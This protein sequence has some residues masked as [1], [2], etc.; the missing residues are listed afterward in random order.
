MISPVLHSG[1]GNQLFQ[2]AAAFAYAKQLN[3]PL[4]IN[5]ALFVKSSH[6][7][8]DYRTNVFSKIVAKYQI[9]DQ[10]EQVYINARDDASYSDILNTIKSNKGLNSIIDGY[11]QWE[12]IFRGYRN[13]I[14]SQF[15]ISAPAPAALPAGLD[16]GFFLHFRRGDY[17]GSAFWRDLTGYYL[18]VIPLV[19]ELCEGRKGKPLPKFF[20]IS[21]DIEYC[22]TSIPY[23]S[24]LDVEFI[25]SADYSEIETMW[26]M[27]KCQLG[28][29]A[30]NSTFSW[31]GLY[32]NYERPLLCIP[33]CFDESK[34]GFP[35]VTIVRC[36]AS[37][38]ASA[39]AP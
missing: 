13:E 17:V 3:T 29:A 34:Y 22:K 16:R 33:D 2:F 32:L 10:S 26:I 24:D 1:L 8:L 15:V 18:R 35:E 21:D 28:G 25:G 37:A 9:N 23:L 11:F 31:W 20:I 19:K 7:D 38:Q 14:I 4:N 5:Y 6:T 36:E 39:K 27:S 12:S 30:A